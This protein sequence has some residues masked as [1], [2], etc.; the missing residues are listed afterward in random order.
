M[1]EQPE[2]GG[3][4]F[5]VALDSSPGSLSALRSAADLAGRMGV[6]LDAIY[7]EDLNLIRLV[8]YSFVREVSF[9][10]G[11][12]FDIS[13][14]RITLML[15]SQANEARKALANLGRLE[16]IRTQFAVARGMVPAEVIQAAGQ[17]SLLI[18]GKSGWSRGRRLGSTTRLAVAQSPRD[19]LILPEG[20]RFHPP[21]AVIFDG[22]DSSLRA[23]N[24]A[25]ELLDEDRPGELPEMVVI[26][27]AED[28][29]QGRALQARLE[30]WQHTNKR[31]ARY[32]W[33]VG[34]QRLRLAEF[35]RTRRFGGLIVPAPF[36][37]TRVEQV[38]TLIDALDL[39]VLLIR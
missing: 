18:I 3:R 31:D 20:R 39:P 36:E 22:Q 2:K 34:S 26:I 24:F 35:L 38:I 7:V 19:V 37:A 13:E 10:S 6:E 5:L 15:N 1:S 32:F 21:L 8:G 25:N 28:I 14:R 12:V 33:V 11:T 4:K 17:A 29:H 23:L 16:N 30:E 9:Y 27:P